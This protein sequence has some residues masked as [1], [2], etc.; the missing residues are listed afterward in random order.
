MLF[1]PVF[2]E[3]CFRGVLQ[4]GLEGR[5]ARYS[6][7]MC[8]VLFALMHMSIVSAPPKILLGIILAYTAYAT[9]SVWCPIIIHA[10]NNIAAT[11]LSF[12]PI[13]TEAASVEEAL[14]EQVLDIT[15]VKLKQ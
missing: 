12:L 2:E 8:G 9:N 4:R 15:K 10:V 1:A 7:I 14:N 13:S 3:F 11:V 5:G 6:I